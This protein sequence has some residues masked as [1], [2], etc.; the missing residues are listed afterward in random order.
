VV[1]TQHMPAHFTS[2]FA[3][4]LDGLCAPQVKEA[5]NQAPLMPGHIYLAPGNDAHLTVSGKR[6]LQCR[7]VV[8]EKVMGHRPSVDMLFHSVA[9]AVGSDA[10]GVIL[11]GMGQDGA[12]GLLAMRQ[13]GARTIGQD[14][15]TCVVYGMPRVAHECGAV[16]S[17][18]SLER[19][20]GGVFSANLRERQT[21]ASC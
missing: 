15:R 8:G 11:T 18:M 4:R 19:I 21:Y 12:Q 1:V 13:A 3:E 5:Y 7:L 9:K 10:V 14:K 6:N 16:G 20:A 2:R 17:Q